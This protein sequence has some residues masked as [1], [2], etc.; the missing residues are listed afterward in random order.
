M[1]LSLLRGSLSPLQGSLKTSERSRVSTHPNDGQISHF[2][3]IFGC[4]KARSGLV[5]PRPFGR[6]RSE[7]VVVVHMTLDQVMAQEVALETVVTMV[8]A[9]T[10]EEEAVVVEDGE[11]TMALAQDMDSEVDMDMAVVGKEEVAEMDARAQEWVLGSSY[12]RGQLM[13]T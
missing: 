10:V 2:S 13:Y 7:E 6:G 12:E 8:V 9:E 3:A 1:L 4:G 5:V 11:T